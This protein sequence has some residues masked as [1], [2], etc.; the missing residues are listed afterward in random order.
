M[1][2][3]IKYLFRKYLDNTCSREEYN[4]LFASL[5]PNNYDA[6]VEEAFKQVE[7]Q[8]VHIM[9]AGKNYR[10]ALAIA[11]TI[12]VVAAA[13]VLWYSR[14][15]Q[16]TT[17]FAQVKQRHMA[18]TLQKYTHRS[19]YKYLLLP[20]STQVWLNAASTLEFP[21]VFERSARKVYLKGE[22]YFDVKHAAELPF[23]IY[24]GKVSTEVLGTAFNIKAYPDLEKIT[25]SVN[26][27]KVKV[28]Y[29]NRQ[30][31]LLTRGQEVSIASKDQKVKEKEL[32]SPDNLAWHKGNLDY[33]D[34]S[35]RDIISD[36]QRVYDV[37]IR[38]AVP[39]VA[40]LRVSTTFKRENGIE[41]ALDI[42]CR[43]TET[44]LELRN[45]I[46]FI[47]K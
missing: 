28:N 34:Y 3:R 30:V 23:I 17:P 5:K 43:L 27:G 42:L 25:V 12:V 20:D 18:P 2:E 41:P 7:L 40:T 37:Q 32:K 8:P 14:S 46:Y 36:L 31:A 38:V 45:G 33:D 19:E 26:R 4:E 10:K 24:T 47:T 13:T 16:R 1:N 6:A 15:A 44:R 29:A 22:A 11:A 9:P 39:Q 35:I 21:E